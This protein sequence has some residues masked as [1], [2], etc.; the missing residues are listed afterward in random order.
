M[1]CVLPASDLCCCPYEV[2]E[3]YTTCWTAYETYIPG[4]PRFG[5]YIL[6]VA[7][8]QPFDADIVAG[9][10]SRALGQR[11][12]PEVVDLADDSEEEEQGR[13]R[14]AAQA[15]GTKQGTAGASTA[16][17]AGHR[18]SALPNVALLLVEPS[19]GEVQLGMAT[20]GEGRDAAT[21]HL[22]SLE[23]ALLMTSPTEVLLA[24][25]VSLAS[26]RL[27]RTYAVRILSC[28]RV[29]SHR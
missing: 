20:C 13:G 2:D 23:G 29:P 27:L 10:G 7:E 24:E 14:G 11:A 16:T 1:Y 15:Q 3:L 19:T 18:Q 21:D 12:A 17:K 8:E 25:P 28:R 9:R 26:M 5:R 6:Y 22:P 4:Q